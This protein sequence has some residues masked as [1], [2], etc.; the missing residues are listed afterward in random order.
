MELIFEEQEWVDEGGIWCPETKC[1]CLLII[2]IL[3]TLFIVTWTLLLRV[4]VQNIW[5]KH[6]YFRSNNG[7]VWC[8]CSQHVTHQ[9]TGEEIETERHFDGNLKQT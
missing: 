6:Q 5:Y 2:S 3:L 9:V 4:S 7:N 1:V 8:V